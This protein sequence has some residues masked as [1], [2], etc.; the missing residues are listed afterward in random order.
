M[1][2][3]IAK[4]R[5]RLNDWQKQKAIGTDGYFDGIG[6]YM[7]L[8]EDDIAWLLE[9]VEAERDQKERMLKN[10]TQAQRSSEEIQRITKRIH[11]PKRNYKMNVT[12]VDDGRKY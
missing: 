11:S 4:I 10:L 9:A 6:H 2:D 1:S 7:A 3:R 5:E 12:W 8:F